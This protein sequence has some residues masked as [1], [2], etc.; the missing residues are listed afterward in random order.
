MP[1]RKKARLGTTKRS[2]SRRDTV[3]AKNATLYAKRTTRGRFK[4][5][6]EKSRALKVD[7]RTKARRTVRSG[8]GDQGDRR[9]A[10]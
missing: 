2:A 5:M 1:A 4:E 7:R 8:Y 10:A 6:D 3:R 9:R